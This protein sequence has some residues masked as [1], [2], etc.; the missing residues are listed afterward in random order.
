M[1]SRVNHLLAS[2]AVVLSFAPRARAE[3]TAPH[4][5]IPAPAHGTVSLQGG[6][7]LY[8]TSSSAP[9]IF[10]GPKLTLEYGAPA[11]GRLSF[12]AGAGLT[13][14]ACMKRGDE[15]DCVFRPGYAVEPSAGIVFTSPRAGRA[16][17][18]AKVVGGMVLL[19]PDA[20][21]VGGAALLRAG[22]GAR[23][24]L[25]ERVAIGLEATAAIGIG[26]FELNYREVERNLV[27]VE[28]GAV[29]KVRL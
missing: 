19:V 25:S 8:M 10:A 3:L 13:L 22:G 24:D 9:A 12:T 18:Y 21:P 11:A 27:S 1:E 4:D 7:S 5:T 29:F 2:A 6:T 14:G 17:A 26:H 28:L 20:H 16:W 15:K 23:Y